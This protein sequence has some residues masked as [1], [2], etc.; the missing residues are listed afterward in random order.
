MSVTEEVAKVKADPKPDHGSEFS[1]QISRHKEFR[2]R[3]L[4]AGVKPKKQEFSIPLMER[5]GTQA[6]SK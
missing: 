1:E 3:M 5:I 2:Q 4:A 6:F